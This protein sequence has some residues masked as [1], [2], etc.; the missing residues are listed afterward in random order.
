MTILLSVLFQSSV[1]ADENFV[2]S[3]LDVISENS[4]RSYLLYVHA[5]KQTDGVFVSGLLKK[6][7]HSVRSL[8][9]HIHVEFVDNEGKLLATKKIN[10][11]GVRWGSI[12]I[13]SVFP[14]YLGIFPKRLRLLR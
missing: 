7:R 2:S 4:P 8:L 10:L 3:Q 5:T 13:Q 11:P 12:S 14:G 6:R 9:G 1:I